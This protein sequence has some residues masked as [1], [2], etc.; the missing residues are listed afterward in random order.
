M[1]YVKI[2]TI[3]T[4]YP[5]KDFIYLFYFTILYWFCYTLTWSFVTL[6]AFLIDAF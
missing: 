5:K 3:V 4:V 2:F 6:H 1:S